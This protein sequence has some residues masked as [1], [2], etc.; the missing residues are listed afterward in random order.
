MDF[1]FRSLATGAA[2][3]AFVAAQ[4]WI[5]VGRVSPSPQALSAAGSTPCSFRGFPGAD[6][7]IPG[8]AGRIRGENPSTAERGERLGF[9]TSL[10]SSPAYQ[11]LAIMGERAGVRAE[12]SEYG[13]RHTIFSLE[14]HRQACSRGDTMQSSGLSLRAQIS[15]FLKRWL[16]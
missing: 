5:A 8:L 15:D 11:A 16:E 10:R 13:R 14:G 7:R 3:R 12:Y 4:G 6:Q 9:A 1:T 2:G